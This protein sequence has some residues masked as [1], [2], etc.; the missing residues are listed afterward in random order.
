MRSLL[1]LEHKLKSKGVKL[2]AGVGLD[3]IGALV[4]AV[5]LHIRLVPGAGGGG[6]PAS[7]LCKIF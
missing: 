2:N 3:S 5:P 7:N 4:G 1:S 6:G